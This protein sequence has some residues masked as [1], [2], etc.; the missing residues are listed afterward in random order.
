MKDIELLLHNNIYRYKMQCSFSSP[1]LSNQSCWMTGQCA[2]FFLFPF[3]F[4][5]FFSPA[6]PFKLRQWGI[7]F[8]FARTN[9]NNDIAWNH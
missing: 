7:F 8:V 6:T 9:L 4:F 3:S 2:H 5:L 1:L